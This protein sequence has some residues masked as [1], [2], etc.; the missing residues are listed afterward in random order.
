MTRSLVPACT[1]VVG[2]IAAMLAPGIAT[3]A[4]QTPDRAQQ[5]SVPHAMETPLHDVNVLRQHIPAVLL[6]AVVDPYA[7]PDR[8]T[9]PRLV[10]LV[11]ELDRA[12]GPDFNM[13]DTPQNPSLTQGNG[14]LALTL[15]SGATRLLIPYDGLVRTVTGAQRHDQMV[16]EAITAGSVRR[17]Y[18][19]GLGE[20]YHCRPPALPAH[21]I[22]NPTPL[23]EARKPLYPIR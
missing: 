16:I 13:P 3:P 20:A 4:L 21:R 8:L 2:L 6:A 19:K 9:C 10:E 12:L 5:S 1:L 18:L 14:H 23:Q 7:A 22:D 17:G 15:L 11:S